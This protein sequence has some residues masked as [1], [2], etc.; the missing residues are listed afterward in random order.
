MIF[1]KN[2]GAIEMRRIIYR[3]NDIPQDTFT[4]SISDLMS[5]LLAIFILVLSYF[6][7]NFSQATAQLTQNDVSRAE[8]LR[9]LRHELET[10]GIKVTV[11]EQHGI[12]RISEGVLFDVGRA[13]VKPQ[14]LVVIQKLGNILA[15][16][17]ESE[18]F[19]GRVETIFIEGHTDNV[20]IEN[21]EFPSN[22][23]LSVKRAINTWQTMSGANP[24]LTALLNNKG[25]VIFSVSGYA[26]TRPVRSNDTLEGRQENRRIDIRFS[27]SPPSEEDMSVVKFVRERW[28]HE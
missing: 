28:S 9:L 1:T 26:E 14:G 2:G 4:V 23:E 25:E 7:L 21:A 22:W 13:D 19:K 24:K 3:D 27:M 17:L 8:L 16:T 18:H 6:I 12:L 5:G 15:A 20:P 11:D 10:E